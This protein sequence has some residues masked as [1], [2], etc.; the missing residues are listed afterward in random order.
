MRAPFSIAALAKLLLFFLLSLDAAGAVALHQRCNFVD[1]DIV[2]I[3]L[4]GML[5]TG[6]RHGKF[7]GFL[8]IVAVHERVDESRAEGVAAAHAVDDMHGVFLGKIRFSRP[9]KA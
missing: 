9:H 1:G 8:I 2:E 7:D 5:K 3:R 6:G 4:D